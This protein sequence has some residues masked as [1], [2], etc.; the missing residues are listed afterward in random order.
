M[1]SL[2]S[3]TAKRHTHAAQAS[4]AH[5]EATRDATIAQHFAD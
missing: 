2:V 3:L 1:W 4:L 5:L